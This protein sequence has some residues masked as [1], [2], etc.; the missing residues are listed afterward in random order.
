M[1][2][3]KGG[4]SWRLDCEKG[5]VEEVSGG[6]AIRRPRADADEIISMDDNPHPEEVLLDGFR[7]YVLNDVEPPFSVR[8]IWRLWALST[9]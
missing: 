5:T 3:T 1:P 8:A 7:D 4:S 6:L 9:L 2:R